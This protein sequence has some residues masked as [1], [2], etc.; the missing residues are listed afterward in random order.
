MDNPLGRYF[1]SYVSGPGI[2]KWRHYF[3]VYHRHLERFR[4]TEVKILEVGIYS[5][6]SLKMWRDYFGP[7]STV[8]GVDIDPACKTYETDGIRVFIGDQ[9]SHSFWSAFRRE[10]DA[11]DVVIDDGGHRSEQQI[12]TFEA[13]LPAIRPGG[14]YICEDVHGMTNPFFDYVIG[15][16]RT[17]HA[18]ASDREGA[19]A[20]GVQR[21]IAGV[22]VYPY[23][24]VINKH[25]R[26]VD[27]LEAVRRGTEWQPFLQDLGPGS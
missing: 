23:M 21:C 22:H 12:T 5:G 26:P 13:L 24:V 9:A 3:D 7:Q 4:G 17:L 15:L 8:F 6:G 1:D 25:A 18:M 14:V 2:W 10:V 11:I 19:A 16:A 20:N 27:R